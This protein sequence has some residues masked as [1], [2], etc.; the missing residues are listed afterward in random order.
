MWND[1]FRELL[2]LKENALA[3]SQS[4]L[5]VA[6]AKIQSL[7]QYAD[8]AFQV[9][10]AQQTV[11]QAEHETV[12]KAE[13]ASLVSEVERLK[14]EGTQLREEIGRLTSG[15]FLRLFGFHTLH[16]HVDSKPVAANATSGGE[17]S[18]RSSRPSERREQ[19]VAQ[20]EADGGSV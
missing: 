6:Q 10:K 17:R 14:K 1:Q 9:F 12:H 18:A 20:A 19:S 4:Q 11:Q 5:N 8:T 16:M 2:A 3:E 13:K 7:L 15:A